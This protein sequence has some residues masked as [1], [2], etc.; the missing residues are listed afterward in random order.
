M[1]DQTPAVAAAPVTIDAPKRVGT[2][3]P[4][5]ETHAIQLDSKAS[6]ALALAV[7]S[8]RNAGS[9]PSANEMD[10]ASDRSPSARPNA[11]AHASKPL[12]HTVMAYAATALVA[13]CAGWVGATA[14]AAMGRTSGERPWAETTQ[15][16]RQNQDDVAR[17][18]G[19]LAS[20]K[21]V[22]DA[23]RQ[24]V[25]Q[26]R[27]EAGLKQS[28]IVERLDRADK[29]PVEMATTLA[30][31]GEQLTRLEAGAPDSTL[32]LD[33]LGERLDRIERHMASAADAAAA[34]PVSAAAQSGAPIPAAPDLPLQTGSLDASP[35]A[36]DTPVDGWVL[37]EVSDGIALIESRS[38]R[39]IE[40][41]PGEM[42]PG[43]GRVEAIERRGKRWV[44]VTSKGVIATVR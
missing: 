13:L 7:T 17:L 16:L 42:V 24:N 25:D 18:S 9:R 41:G 6:A 32:K 43:V 23:L 21:M 19:D 39:L 44:V 33:A 15:A 1:S 20:I 10:S 40:V 30:R 31:F 8:A 34:K 26:S 2:A 11:A 38:R 12:R 37:H 5:T 22:I 4:R 27:A 14:L 36:R 29:T 28:Q 35:T 3:Q